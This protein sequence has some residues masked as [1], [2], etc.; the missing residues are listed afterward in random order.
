MIWNHL[1][2]C[3]YYS[4]TLVSVGFE[5]GLESQ[6]IK[7]VTIRERNLEKKQTTKKKSTFEYVSIFIS[8]QFS[9]ADNKTD[10]GERE[11]DH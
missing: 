6:K 10:K 3:S 9:A 2:L 4:P 5:S 11:E 8:L 7:Y 1:H